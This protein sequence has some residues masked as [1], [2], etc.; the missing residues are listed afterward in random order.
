MLGE[1][2]RGRKGRIEAHC[3]LVQ[4]SHPN[5]STRY[6]P[7]I[8]KEALLQLT[9]TD[10]CSLSP[11]TQCHPVLTTCGS[12]PDQ[13]LHYLSFTLP[14]WM[15]LLALKKCSA[16]VSY[17]TSPQ[18]SRVCNPREKVCVID[19]LSSNTGVCSV[20][21]LHQGGQTGSGVGLRD[22]Q[23]PGRAAAFGRFQRTCQDPIRK[24]CHLGLPD[25]GRVRATQSLQ[26][27]PESSCPAG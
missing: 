25:I 11:T 23:R 7:E 21:S 6:S 10:R 15:P 1:L 8:R 22:T 16:R 12:P 4:S 3:L 19:T 5:G 2:L 18:T 27:K 14:Q 17:P 24:I 9:V 26:P 20:A 13:A